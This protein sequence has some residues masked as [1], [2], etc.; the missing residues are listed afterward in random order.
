MKLLY[1]HRFHFIR[2]FRNKTTYKSL[3]YIET[4]RFKLPGCKEDNFI[5]TL[6]LKGL[7]I[8]EISEA[9]YGETMH[10]FDKAH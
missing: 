6:Y 10:V 4:E 1:E 8:D 7:G 5:L 9:S 2:L 3:H